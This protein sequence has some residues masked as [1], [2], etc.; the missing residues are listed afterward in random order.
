MHPRLALLARITSITTPL[1]P[2][3]LWYVGE[4]SLVMALVVGLLLLWVWA[5]VARQLG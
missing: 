3:W 1:L 2:V 4:M 5:E